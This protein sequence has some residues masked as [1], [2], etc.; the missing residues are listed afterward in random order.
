M[1]VPIIMVSAHSDEAV[2]VK[3]LDSGADDYVTKPFRREEFL[4]RIRAKLQ[5]ATGAAEQVHVVRFRM[6]Y[7]GTAVLRICLHKQAV[8]D[9]MWT[10][11]ALPGHSH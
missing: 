7:A 8:H 2:V 6:F 11:A 4:A 10:R 3:G 5:L 1:P 9:C